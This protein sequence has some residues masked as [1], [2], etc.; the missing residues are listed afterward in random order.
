MTQITR[1]ALVAA[2]GT[3][4]VAAPLRKPR[5][6]ELAGLDALHSLPT[7]K[8][9]DIH[10]T[11]ADGTAQSVADYAGRG[12]V[13]NLWATWCVPCVREMPALALLARVLAHDRIVVLPLSSDHAGAPVV[14]KF[15]ADHDITGLPVLLDPRGAAAQALN[16]RGIP[17][18]LIIDQKGQEVAWLEGSADWSQP[19]LTAAI[20]RMIGTSTV[21][22]A[23][24]TKA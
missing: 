9:V 16:V 3:L 21:G 10:F 6:Q 1:R 24:V 14:Q 5:A 4:A 15:F 23:T 2:A 17:T 11:T 19:D 8:P 13:L 12:V 22:R 7:P 18:T 20:R